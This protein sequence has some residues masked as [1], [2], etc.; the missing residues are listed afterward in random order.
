VFQSVAREVMAL[1]LF[2]T[3][4]FLGSFPAI[5]PG[6]IATWHAWLSTSQNTESW[7][8]LGAAFVF[9]GLAG[10]TPM[11]RVFAGTIP[12][13]LGR[14]S[15]VLYLVH[16]P[17][18]CCVTAWLAWW[19]SG[20]ITYYPLLAVLAG[21]GSLA[22]VIGAA[23]LLTEFVDIKTTRLSRR[24]GEAVDWLLSGA[25]WRP[26]GQKSQAVGDGC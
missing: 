1:A 19:L 15:F 6:Q 17:L 10:S 22:V 5:H 4:A 13:F 26:R 14:I 11:R 8:R 25:L 7:H 18:V 9:A 21:S 16:I 3:G 24:A 23:T 12:V 20:P 2:V